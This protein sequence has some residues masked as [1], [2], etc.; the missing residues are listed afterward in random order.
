[1]V[2]FV[3]A[4]EEKINKKH[5]DLIQFTRWQGTI[6]SLRGKTTNVKE[7]PDDLKFL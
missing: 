3:Y 7:L 2:E 1:M 5:K 6:V 4:I